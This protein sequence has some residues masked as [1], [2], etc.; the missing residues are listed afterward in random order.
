MVNT[1]NTLNTTRTLNTILFDLDGTLLQLTQDAFLGAYIT[2]LKEV[3]VRLNMDAGKSIDAVW[4]GTRA[5]MRNDGTKL[6]SNRFWTE[7]VDVLCLSEAQQKKVE[8]ACDDFYANEFDSVKSIMRPNSIS[9]R[10][11][12][13]LSKKGYTVVL[14]TN[15]LFPACAVATRLGWIGLEPQDFLYLTHYA[16]SMYCKPNPGYFRDILEKINKAP[17]NCLM[18]GN[19]P[20]EDMSAGELGI[21]TFLVTDCLE[22]EASVDISVYKRGTLSELEALLMTLSNIA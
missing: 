19:N 14:A 21:E 5:M 6:N 3:F 1:T 18:I 11:V 17:E 20:I 7:F 4:A 13:E 15:P 9:S 10:L 22:A 12:R 2:K 8:A 16:N